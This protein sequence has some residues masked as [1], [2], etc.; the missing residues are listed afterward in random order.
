MTRHECDVR[1][2]LTLAELDERAADP[3]VTEQRFLAAALARLDEMPPPSSRGSPPPAERRPC[4]ICQS[5]DYV[6]TEAWTRF[7]ACS[8]PACIWTRAVRA[9]DRQARERCPLRI[10]GGMADR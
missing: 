6:T 7:P 8:R 9:R 1:N 3:R 10:V 5:L 2:W 4:P